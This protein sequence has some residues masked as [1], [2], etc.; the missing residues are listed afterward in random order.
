MCI[1][2]Y[3]LGGRRDK[4]FDRLVSLVIKLVKGAPTEQWLQAK[5]A[6]QQFFAICDII[7]SREKEEIGVGGLLSKP[8]YHFCFQITFKF[9]LNKKVK[10]G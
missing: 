1:C 2:V 7:G 6:G 10:K 5:G 8:L 4:E 3:L 9:N